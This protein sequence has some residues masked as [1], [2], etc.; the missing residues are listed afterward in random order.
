MKYSKLTL[1]RCGVS[2]LL[3]GVISSKPF[4]VTCTSQFSKQHDSYLRSVFLCAL[5]V[6]SRDFCR[7]FLRGQVWSESLHQNM[8]TKAANCY[9][10]LAFYL[11]CDANSPTKDS[12]QQAK[13]LEW[14]AVRSFLPWHSSL[15]GQSWSKVPKD[16][17]RGSVFLHMSW[18]ELLWT[19]I[20]QRV[21]SLQKRK[22]L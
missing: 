10:F 4:A 3:G 19:K 14:K 8:T 16:G 5:Q 7:T 11:A 17:H 2:L 1:K 18:W 22:W 12:F 6:W 20:A 21:W 15:T 13:T 9:G